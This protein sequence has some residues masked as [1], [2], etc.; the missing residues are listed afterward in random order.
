MTFIDKRNL[1][2]AG[3]QRR[4]MPPVNQI[5]STTLAN[6]PPDSIRILP[7]SNSRDARCIAGRNVEG[8]GHNVVIE[9]LGA[10]VPDDRRIARS[11]EKANRRRLAPVHV[12]RVHAS[13]FDELPFSYEL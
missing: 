3:H 7:L 11:G 13:Q 1:S 12:E 6:F 5:E 9:Q 4:N 8:C 2:T 10:R